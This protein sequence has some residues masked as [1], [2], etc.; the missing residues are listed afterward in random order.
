MLTMAI[1]AKQSIVTELINQIFEKN[2]KF[3][4]LQVNRTCPICRADAVMK[5]GGF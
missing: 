4:M 1:P 3:C 2:E 5:R